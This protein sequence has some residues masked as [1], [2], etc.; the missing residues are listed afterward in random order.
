MDKFTDSQII[1][2]SRFFTY[3]DKKMDIKIP[4]NDKFLAIFSFIFS[5]LFIGSGFALL[6][7]NINEYHDLSRYFL[8]LMFSLSIMIFG[9][10]AI[11]I[12]VAPVK[13]A[14]MII[15]EMKKINENNAT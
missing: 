5:L 15:R 6:M 1:I 12:F 8:I 13:V 14:S 7:H 9:F 4:W 3:I 11:S 2:A 10:Y